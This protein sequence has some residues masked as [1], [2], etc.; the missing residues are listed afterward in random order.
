[1]ASVEV[2]INGRFY[3]IA[4][5]DGQEP[6]LIRLAGMVDEKVATLVGQVGQVGDTRLLVMACLL[7]ADEMEDL[8]HDTGGAGAGQ[9]N[10]DASAA[11]AEGIL[12]MAE[13]I[14]RIAATLEK[15]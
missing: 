5:E 15:P 13:R 10:G 6:R 7:I 12:G 9:P 2:S 3:R 14:E 11:V 4:C 8:R 1:M